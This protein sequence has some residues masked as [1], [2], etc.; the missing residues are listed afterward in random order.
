MLKIWKLVNLGKFSKF[1]LFP[2]RY[3]GKEARTKIFSSES[4]FIP[5]LRRLLAAALSARTVLVTRF[6]S[7]E[8]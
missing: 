2:I 5:S 6:T 7:R 1:N 4:P 3:L 8:W